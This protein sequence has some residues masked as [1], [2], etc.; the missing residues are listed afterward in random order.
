MNPLTVG[1]VAGGLVG[2][3]VLSVHQAV[4]RTP[5]S[6]ASAQRRLHGPA[7]RGATTA[8]P[9]APSSLF[10]D[11]PG[12]RWVDRTMGAGLT[13]IGL[14]PASV[15]SRVLSSVGIVLVA[16]IATLAALGATGMLPLA[17]WLFA[18]PGLAA[19]AAGWV[20][21]DDIRSRIDRQSRALQRAA[22]ELVQLVAIGL[23]TD[24]SVEEAIRFALDVGSSEAFDMLRNG[25]LSA[26][27]RGLP[28]WEALHELGVTYGIRE[29]VDLA[30][31]VE[32]QGLHGVSIAETV[33][34]LAASMRAAS[35]DRLEREADQ[36]NANLAGPT[37]GFV[38][39]TVVFL[40]YPLA[41]RINEA[42]GG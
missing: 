33:G 18:I 27:Q 6:L 20:T 15:V 23:T 30:G 3:A 34:S 26:P 9:T 35:L 14:D 36:A 39:A 17:P 21:L 32:R 41:V 19:V 7:T 37:V 16:G 8:R 31:S 38:V 1:A 42:F 12:A 22:N 5:T 24:Q 10:V 40:A 29:L 28:V 2:S 4:R 25:V 11:N 13:S